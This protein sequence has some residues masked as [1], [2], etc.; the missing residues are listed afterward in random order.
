MLKTVLPMQGAGVQSLVQEL[1]PHM[2]RSVAKNSLSKQVGRCQIK[3]GLV[4]TIIQEHVY[5]PGHGISNNNKLAASF[6]QELGHPA[7]LTRRNYTKKTE[8][9]QKKKK[10]IIATIYLLQW[11]RYS[12]TRFSVPALAFG[13]IVRILK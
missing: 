2:P 4:C 5:K 7:H 13:L 9:Y 8:F 12:D 6:G 3:K 10:D 11:P 1:R